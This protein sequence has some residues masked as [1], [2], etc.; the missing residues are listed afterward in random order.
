[1]LNIFIII[2]F[3]PLL[4]L[5]VNQ[6]GMKFCNFPK[7]SCTEVITQTKYVKEDTDFGM[8]RII[9]NSKKGTCNRN[10]EVWEDAIIIDNNATISNLIL[11]ESP[12]GTASSI[13]C[14]GSCTLKN[15]Y[16]ENACWRGFSFIGASNVQPGEKRNYTY[17]VDGGAVLDGFQK[18]IGQGERAMTIVKDFCSVNNSI[19]ICSA[20]AG[21]IIVVDTRFKGPMLNI[22]CTN[23]KHKDRLTLR[24][25]TL[26]GNN[27]PATKIKYACVEHIENQV[28]D[29]NPWKYAYKPGEAG[30]S[31]VSCK[32]PASAFK[33]IN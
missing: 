16:M 12:I 31:D 18:I 29:A 13:T 6:E 20:G 3:M 4:S 11:G 23:R 32:Y 28:S 15:V 25:I 17:V 8:K 24:N 22:L 10:L 7:P 2:S 9:F 21:K 14:K 26:Y 1:M 30:S 19:G 5:A 27:N 33:I